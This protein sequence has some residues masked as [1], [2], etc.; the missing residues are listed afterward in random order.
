MGASALNQLRARL[1][2]MYNPPVPPLDLE[3]GEG[4][5][6]TPEDAPD[7][8]VVSTEGG[9]LVREEPPLASEVRHK[10][11]KKSRRRRDRDLRGEAEGEPGEG[12]P[13]EGLL[14]TDLSEAGREL[15]EAQVDG[16][17]EGTCSLITRGPHH[18]D[19]IEELIP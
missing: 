12:I 18:S 5:G 2:P 11:G 1:D 10:K 3:E 17:V 8:H 14:T 15:L 6:L 9:S 4:D 13:P 7:R 19:A 16:I